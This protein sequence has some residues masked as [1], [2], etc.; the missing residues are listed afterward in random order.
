MAAD[1]RKSAVAKNDIRAMREN[2]DRLAE[3]FDRLAEKVLTMA[4]LAN[5]ERRII[6]A[7]WIQGGAIVVG[8]VALLKFLE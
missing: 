1:A 6:R 7:M 8:V 2:L 3:N 4:D 5:F